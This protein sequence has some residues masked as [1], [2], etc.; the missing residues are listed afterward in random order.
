[1]QFSTAYNLSLDTLPADWFFLFIIPVHEAPVTSDKLTNSQD[2]W[3]DIVVTCPAFLFLATHKAGNAKKM[4][5]LCTRDVWKGFLW[6]SAKHVSLS[7]FYIVWQAKGLNNFYMAELSQ[8]RR[9]SILDM[10]PTC[11]WARPGNWT[12]LAV[13]LSE[14]ATTT[15]MTPA[16]A[17]MHQ[18]YKCQNYD[19]CHHPA[20]LTTLI[21]DYE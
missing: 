17:F 21:T 20:M 12:R 19:R 6:M 18:S 16:H 5:I 1:M 10:N 15:P 8:V 9:T 2:F 7:I 11:L 3:P 13:M 14:A 4:I